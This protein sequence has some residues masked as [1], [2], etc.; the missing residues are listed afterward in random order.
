ML[1][2]NVQFSGV[3]TGRVRGTLFYYERKISMASNHTKNLNLNQWVSSDTILRSDFNSDNQKIDA[4]LSNIPRIVAGSYTGTG[5]YGAD[6]P[7]TLTFAFTPIL[8]IITASSTGGVVP[9]S[10]FI[11]NQ[12]KSD[13][14]GNYDNPSFGLDLHLTWGD[15]RVSWYT[16]STD[17]D[18]AALQLNKDG[19]IY[20]YF[21]IGL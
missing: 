7:R 6:N 11:V 17:D 21:A 18:A 12:V 5:T 4:A 8:V 16:A 15:D 1:H 14:I 9:G 10:V 20:R 13:G 3:N 19:Q 2:A